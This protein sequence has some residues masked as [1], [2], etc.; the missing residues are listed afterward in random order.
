MF[1]RHSTPP[2]NGLYHGWTTCKSSSCTELMNRI[3]HSTIA[4]DIDPN[5]PVITSSTKQDT[6]ALVCDYVT[7]VR[8]FESR[9]WWQGRNMA[10]TMDCKFNKTIWKGYILNNPSYTQG[11]RTSAGMDNNRNFGSMYWSYWSPQ[12]GV[13]DEGVWFGSRMGREG[14]SWSFIWFWGWWAGRGIAGFLDKAFILMKTSLD[15]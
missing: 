13:Y 5:R 7:Q 1:I 9:H 8:S 6:R 11:K 14:R 10:R 3:P 2:P 12:F 4:T 15:D